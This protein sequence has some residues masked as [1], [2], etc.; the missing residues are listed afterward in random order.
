MKDLLS[1]PKGKAYFSL[2]VCNLFCAVT[3]AVYFVLLPAAG[4]AW[5][6]L[7]VLWF[8]VMLANMLL[9]LTKNKRAALRRIAELLPILLVVINGMMGLNTSGQGISYA[10]QIGAVAYYLYAGFYAV[11]MGDDKRYPELPVK[12]CKTISRVL[13]TM[14]FV[15]VLLLSAM[16]SV[17]MVYRQELKM[18]SA[19]SYLTLGS[20]FFPVCVWG[21]AA[22]M[23]RRLKLA[24][25]R[26]SACL[27]S[28]IA[29]LAVWVGLTP[30]FALPS[31]LKNADKAYTRSFGEDGYKVQI[32]VPEM[33]FAG[34]ERGYMVTKDVVYRSYT[35]EDATWDLAFDMYKA[36]G[37]T[38]ATPVVITLHGSGGSKGTRNLALSSEAIASQG[39]TVF[40]VNYGNEHAKPSNDELAENV[41]AFLSYLYKNKETLNIDTDKIFLTGSSRG[42]KIALKAATLWA[43]DAYG[44]LRRDVT[45]QGLVLRWSFMNDV[46]TREG[47][48]RVVSEQ[49]LNAEMPPIL[50][51]D[52]TNDGSVQGGL[53]MEGFLHSLGVTSA[54][55]E[56]R[57]AM[58]SANLNYYGPWGQMTDAYTLRFLRQF[59]Q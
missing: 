37:E 49:E 36:A 52:T 20:M 3:A 7:G 35:Y 1:Q 11:Y 19:F 53:M 24:G 57:Y 47:K 25:K 4:R 21:S 2:A 41:C 13:Y 40:D 12:P 39:Y 58:H 31:A 56:L 18:S 28:G 26:T 16:F 44:T 14:L 54:N 33:L 43:N 23:I 38:A 22:N 29:L 59:S 9:P 45:I 55:I 42:G 46:F 51:I 10:V 27:V 30:L 8:V 17:H 34:T 6:F 5:N 15:F 50:F 32:S 48:E